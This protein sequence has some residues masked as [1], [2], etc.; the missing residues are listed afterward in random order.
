MV[1]QDSQNLPKKLSM[2][3]K[4]LFDRTC[5]LFGLIVLSPV[6]LA[7]AIL[8]RAKMPGGPVIFKQT[9][10]GRYG[11]PFTMCKFRSMTM[12]HG[13]SSISIKGE[14]RITPLG[15]VL[16]KYKLDELPE[17]WNVLKGDMSLVGPRP[18]VPG[19]ADKLQGGDR[20]ILCLRPGITGPASLKYRNE[21]ELLARQ[22]DPQRYNDEVIFPDK[23]RINRA[24]L[25]RW[26]FALDLKIIFCTV[27]GKDFKQIP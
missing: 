23:T 22:P 2:L 5:A 4:T 16:R 6:L 14:N 9:R 15:S 3:L 10:I 8:I 17:L 7:V 25:E 1:R 13:G 24:Y 20:E 26:S 18:D 19:Y 11:K 27:L 21:E 12:N